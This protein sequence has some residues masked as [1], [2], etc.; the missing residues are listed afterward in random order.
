MRTLSAL[1]HW[2]GVSIDRVLDS[3]DD[4]GDGLQQADS[5][6]DIVE[7]HL[8]ADRN[9]DPKTAAVLGRMFRAAYEQFAES[10]INT[11]E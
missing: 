9:L 7:A 6:P 4:K 2:I 8:R 1:T 10:D 5:T 3:E 11:H